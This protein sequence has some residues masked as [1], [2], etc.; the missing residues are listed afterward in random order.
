VLLVVTVC[1]AGCVS[2]SGNTAPG[3]C[4]NNWW[5][6]VYLPKRL[7]ILESCVTVRGIVVDARYVLDGDAILY[8][9]LDPEYA[10]FSNQKNYE[11]FGNDMLEL[12][13]V[14]RHPVFRFLVFRCWTCGNK[15]LVP[16]VG[17]HIEA[18]GIYVQDT[19]H[20]HLELHPVTRITILRSAKVGEAHDADE[21]DPSRPDRAGRTIFSRDSSAADPNLRS[22][23]LPPCHQPFPAS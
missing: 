5:H 21:A 7:V 3:E 16:R 17:D 9:R 12:E 18:D 13:I 20:M 8:L 2:M 19:R 14:C 22:A 15:I 1:S 11:Q 23:P 4:E 6:C 10:H